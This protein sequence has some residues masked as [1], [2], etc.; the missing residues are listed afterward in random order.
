MKNHGS[1]GPWLLQITRRCSLRLQR[2]RNTEPTG[3][4]CVDLATTQTNDWME[5]YADVVEQLAR[6]PEHERI[7]TVM[8]YVDGHSVKEIANSTGRPVGTI[9]KQL[10][11]AIR[12]LRDWLTQ[13]QL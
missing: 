6:L 7:V 8:R 13:V 2:S 11:R 4:Q 9:T 12:R 1:F 10:S 3:T 5:P